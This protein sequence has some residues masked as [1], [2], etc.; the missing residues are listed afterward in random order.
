MVVREGG[1]KIQVFSALGTRE[2]E[3]SIILLLW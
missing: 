1:R 3:T 2:E